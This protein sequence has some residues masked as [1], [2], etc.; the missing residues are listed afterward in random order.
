MCRYQASKSS[1]IK[2]LELG[3]LTSVSPSA[4]LCNGPIRGGGSAC[5]SVGAMLSLRL[6]KQMGEKRAELDIDR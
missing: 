4:D 3:K 2:S 6:R 5:T 1:T